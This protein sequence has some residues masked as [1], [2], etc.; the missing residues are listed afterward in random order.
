M[1]LRPRLPGLALAALLC[2]AI[3]APG[4][5]QVVVAGTIGTPETDISP[6]QEQLLLREYWTVAKRYMTG[7]AARA[8]REL[9]AWTMDRVGKVQMIQYQPEGAL[10]VTRESYAEWDSKT[11]RS[12]AMLHTDIAL[13]AF[14][15]R[16]GNTF[17]FHLGIADGWLALADDRRSLPN[18]LRSRWN[19]AVA[20]LLLSTGDVALAERHL[21]RIVERIPGD[22]ALLLAYGTVKETQA[23]R[24]R[25]GMSD[26]GADPPAAGVAART[27]LLTAAAALFDKALAID[28]SLDEARVRRAH[29]MWLGGDV[30]GADA[31]LQKV[32][33]AQAPPAIRYLALLFH[34]RVLERRRELDAAAKRYVEAVQ[35]MPDGQTAYLALAHLM[36]GAGQREGGATV[37]DRMFNR[38][39]AAGSIDPWW[40]YPLGL[41]VDLDP[42]F[43]ELRRDAV[44]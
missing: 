41:E 8:I 39:I 28:P 43:A 9:G 5:A 23:S 7:E 30:E 33:A 13:E 20:R 21:A 3:A 27:A 22:A 40:L 17:E 10:S 25:A 31:L 36:H 37:L 44:K 29:V 32:I 11:L 38:G 1:A 15:T 12:A 6:E 42:R 35:V 2:L 24:E 34:G 26:R 16:R 4:A 19:V 14:K 18:S